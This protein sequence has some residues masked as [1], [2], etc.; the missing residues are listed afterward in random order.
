[1]SQM[2]LYSFGLLVFP[3][4]AAAVA[5]GLAAELGAAWAL[6]PAAGLAGAA[7]S[8]AAALR[9]RPEALRRRTL[10][11]L[12]GAAGLLSLLAATQV[13][14]PFSPVAA[15]DRNLWVAAAALA[16]GG[17]ITWT[18]GWNRAGVR[19]RLMLA[20]QLAWLVALLGP[21][22]VPQN[23]RPPALGAVAVAGLVPLKLAAAILYLLCLPALLQ[24]IPEAAPQ[25]PPGGPAGAA[26]LE[27]A[28]FTAV[29]ILLWLPYC[30]LFASLYFPP[31]GDDAL[32]LLRFA[33]LTWGAGAIAASVA[34][35]V[36]RR[37]GG[38][39]RVLYLRLAFPFAVFTLL[40][41][42]LTAALETPNI[43]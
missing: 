4:A 38:A 8:L 30:G 3:G 36:A 18:W 11:P 10:P 29:R 1:M 39:T 32:G 22:L 43:L 2:L 41:A 13:A 5:V 27:Q 28:G 40:L 23:L 17:W 21:A 33:L 24:L 7:R 26:G 19:P 25:G 20:V 31:S 16:A 12:A 42:L 37:G 14:A 15:G 34:A 9:P 6:R 35:I